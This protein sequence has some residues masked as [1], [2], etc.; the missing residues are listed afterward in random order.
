MSNESRTSTAPAFGP[1]GDVRVISMSGEPVEEFDHTK[2]TAYNFR[3]PGFLSQGDLRQLGNMHQRFVQHLAARL[4]T[5]LRMD[6]GLRITKFNSSTF[7]KFC[8]GLANPSHITLFQMDPLR[9]VGIIE[10]SLPMGYAMADRL[11]G[12]KGR[13]AAADRSL[14]EIE[15]ALLED[16]M[17]I[18][19]AEWA[20]LWDDPE[21]VFTPKCIAHETSGRFLQT[22]APDAVFVSMSVEVTLGEMTEQLQMGIPFSMIETIVKKMHHGRHRSSDEARVKKIQWRTPYAGIQVPVV[23]EWKL[24]EL[25]LRDA[26][27]IKPGDLI[28]L[29][30]KLIEQAHVRLGETDEY[31]GTIGVQNEH[32][33]VRISGQIPKD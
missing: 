21:W 16:A 8:E 32:V 25:T 24:R 26:A 4:S 30:R 10:I 9:G 17:Q 1:D 19:L 33:A 3:N 7:T 23:V 14:T 6:C 18:V 2:L 28:E 20:Q 27:E 29:P 15:I 13:M 5:F 11:L 31:L 22:A 12:G